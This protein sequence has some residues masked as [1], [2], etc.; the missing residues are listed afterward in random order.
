VEF[1]SNQFLDALEALLPSDYEAT[2]ARWRAVV[3]AR[4]SSSLS[5]SPQPHK[6][7]RV[8]IHSSSSSS[9]EISSS[10]E[11]SHSS[12]E[13]SSASDTPTSVGPSPD[14]LPPRKRFRGSLT[15]S[16]QEIS[17]EDSIEDGT[18]T[19]IKAMIK[20]TAEMADVP[21]IPYVLP[22][23]T[24]EEKLE[25][26]KEVI[27]GMYE[28][29][30]KMSVMRFEELEEEQKALKDR[31]VTTE[32]ER[33]NLREQVRSLEMSELSLKDSLRVDREAYAR[34]QHQLGFV[35]EELRQSRMAHFTDRESLRIIATTQRAPG[36]NQRTITCYECGKR[37]HFRSGCPKLKNQSREKQAANGEA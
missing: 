22:E 10:S 17:I 34:V 13:T 12:S 31:A 20:V 9:S 15:T 19:S 3:L 27:Q 11:T 2:I 6:R 21:D 35:T 1:T 29:L 32:T 28:H 16:H 26:H 24:V 7:R 36:V 4:P 5:S 30:L 25:E 18:E 8:L 33:T 37:G 14:H 23:P